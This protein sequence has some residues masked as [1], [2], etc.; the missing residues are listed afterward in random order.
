VTEAPLLRA[1][2]LVKRYGRLTALDHV[3]VELYRGEVLGVVGESGSGVHRL[4]E[5]EQP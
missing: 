3:S 2:G 1:E 4:L 5:V